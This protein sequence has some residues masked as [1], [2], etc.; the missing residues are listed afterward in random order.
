MV[1]KISLV[2]M[3]QN[4]YGSTVIYFTRALWRV[5]SSVVEVGVPARV[6]QEEEKG[7]AERC[8]VSWSSHVK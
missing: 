6:M 1:D 8:L 3:S 7:T 5:G 2:L 4:A